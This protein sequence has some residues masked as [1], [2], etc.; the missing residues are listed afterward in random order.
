MRLN[1]RYRRASIT[2]GNGICTMSHVYTRQEDFRMKMFKCF[3][4][5]F[6]VFASQAEADRRWFVQTSDN[7]ITSFTD[8]DSAPTPA[9]TTEVADS[10]IRATDP[11]GATGDITPL[12]TWDG[13]TYTAPSGGGIVVPIDPAT[14][15]GRVM[16][17]AHDLMDEFETALEYIRRNHHIWPVANVVNAREGIYWMHVNAARVALNGTRGAEN[18]IAFLNGTSRPSKAV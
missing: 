4:V 7:R 1:P 16:Q 13:T 14:D 11:P 9:G 2:C 6:L 18:R 8:D 10:V 15:A 12:G 17:A 5:L 3:A